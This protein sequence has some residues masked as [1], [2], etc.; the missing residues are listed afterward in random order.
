MANLALVSG[1]KV[2]PV[3][4]IANGHEQYTFEAEEQ[5]DAGQVFRINTTTGKATK[6]NGTT[7]TEAGQVTALGTFESFLFVAID[8]ARQAGNMVTGM[9][10]G[11]IDGFEISALNFG[12]RIYLSD[13]DGTLADTAGTNSTLLGRV[14]PSPFSGVPSGVDRILRVNCPPAT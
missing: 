14:I 13:T 7:L 10:S 5:I 6:A 8:G 9:K 1:A 12:A 3:S 11:L 4:G 2:R